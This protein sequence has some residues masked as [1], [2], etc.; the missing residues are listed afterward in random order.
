MT[1]QDS[2]SLELGDSI[3]SGSNED[4]IKVRLKDEAVI[5]YL[6]EGIYTS[7]KSAVRELFANELTAALTPKG[8]TGTLK[9]EENPTIEITID[10]DR[11]ELTIQGKHS[12]GITMDTFAEK[13]IY[14]G[15]SGNVSSKRPGRFG[16]GAKAYVSLGKCI[17]IESFA[18]ET[19]E[20]YGVIGSE[21]TQFKRIPDDELTILEHGTKV[22]IILREDEREE[23]AETYDWTRTG[24]ATSDRAKRK[25]IELDELIETIENVC[26]FSDIGTYLTISS[27]CKITKHSSYSRYAYETTVKSQSRKKI[28]FTPRKYAA[29]RIAKGNQSPCQ[30][31]EFELDDPDFYFYGVLAASSR[32][33]NEVDVNSD[34]GEVRLLKMPIEA[35]I[36]IEDSN[37]VTK[38]VKPEYP[39][40][41]WF[42]NLRDEVKFSPTPDR[43]R[44]REGVYC[45]VHKRITEFLKGKFAE[46]EIKS[47][48]DYRDSKYKPILNSHSDR[49][50]QDFLTD[51]TRQIC[52]VLD[53]EVITIGEEDSKQETDQSYRRWRHR[54]SGYNPKLREIVAKTSN[55][56]M[57]RRELTSTGKEFV[58]PKKTALDLR[59]V[60][61]VK[62]PDAIVFLYPAS[63]PS[64]RLNEALPLIL[65]LGRKLSVQFSLKNAKTEA[66]SIKNEL[67][68]G[69]RKIAGIEIKEEILE[70]EREVV[71]WKC[72]RNYGSSIV[73]PIRV[74]PSEIESNTVR[75]TGNMKEWIDLVKK[76]SIRDYGITKEIKGLTSG[77]SEEEFRDLISKKRVATEKGL[78][79]LREVEESVDVFKG[80]IGGNTSVT[81]LRFHDPEILKFYKPE[82]SKV[83]CTRTDKE[84]FEAVAYLKLSNIGFKAT[85]VVRTRDLK[86]ELMECCGRINQTEDS[87]KSIF[88]LVGSAEGDED[89]EESWTSHP[90]AANY[91]FMAVSMMNE[92]KRKSEDGSISSLDRIAR[93]K[94]LI[95]LL[96][97]SISNLY[98]TEKMR[99]MART[100]VKYA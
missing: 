91:L 95:S 20:R 51:P 71:V 15:R 84:T 13:V 18:R 86:R 44:L 36:P 19:G 72:T 3:S 16:F 89:E 39:M 47:F 5:K 46:M 90:D 65:E 57:L 78:K 70:K 52:S 53:T 66:V 41:F 99:L 56:F 7:W 11:R 68:N 82:D 83:I 67:G 85:D 23:V 74:K 9:E 60:I 59:K 80:N 97:D 42:V 77:M 8:I 32:D 38:E 4:I 93:R 37:H 87:E 24:Y 94:K 34:N 31:F 69:W 17:R 1:S 30:H 55:I 21:G 64:W 92:R 27:D 26:R 54:S 6:S 45:E 40:T 98:D 61:R 43:E 29:T 62:Y 81:V 75:I 48:Q 50:L 28:N 2:A 79:T 33:E 76:Y 35:T 14:Y 96:W 58:L 49:Y 88:S 63:Y 25:V 22:S 10:P 73:D 100:A 12:L